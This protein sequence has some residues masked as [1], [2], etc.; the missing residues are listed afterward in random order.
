MKTPFELRGDAF[1]AKPRKHKLA[2][3]RELPMLGEDGAIY[4]KRVICETSVG[5][6]VYTGEGQFLCFV[7]SM[8][9]VMLAAQAE[10]VSFSQVH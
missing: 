7:P 3:A 5:Y 8:G 6:A 10:N 9:D 4:A 2:A 1:A